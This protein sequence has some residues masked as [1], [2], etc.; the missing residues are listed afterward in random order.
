MK[1]DCKFAR[2]NLKCVRHA[3]TGNRNMEIG[4]EIMEIHVELHV[5]RRKGIR[6]EVSY[7]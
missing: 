5:G 4:I 3:H 6:T 2:H 7:Y 1:S